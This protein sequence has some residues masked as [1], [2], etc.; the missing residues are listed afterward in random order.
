[1]AYEPF[2]F[3]AFSSRIDV[4]SLRSCLACHA[5]VMG[6]LDHLVEAVYDRYKDRYFKDESASRHIRFNFASDPPTFCT[7]IYIDIQGQKCVP[8]AAPPSS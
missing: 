1:V 7:E 6:R 5:E 8:P 4:S 2:V 3:S